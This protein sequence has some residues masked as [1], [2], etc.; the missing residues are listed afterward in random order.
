MTRIT[1]ILAGPTPWELEGRLVG[2]QHL[3]LAEEGVAAVS[4]AAASLPHPL[5]V[6]Y[7]PRR[8]EACDEASHIVAQHFRLRARDHDDLEEMSLGLWQGLRLQDL[9]HRFETAWGQWEDNPLAV[10]PPEGEPLA[11]AIA[12]IRPAVC[13]VVRRHRRGHVGLVL[14]P[15]ALQ[16]ALGAL[17]REPDHTIAAHLHDTAA[18][19]TMEL[20]RQDVASLAG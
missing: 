18:M 13:E 7:R 5:T 16:I 15:I 10:H 8:N 4:R 9:R 1:L 17:R 12:R 6:V 3:P 2:A 20:S 11:H 14:R 19:E